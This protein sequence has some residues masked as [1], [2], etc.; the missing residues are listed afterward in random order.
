MLLFVP[1]GL[2]QFKTTVPLIVNNRAVQVEIEITL[3]SLT[4]LLR[5]AFQTIDPLT[6]LPPEGLN[7]FLPP[8]DG[9]GRGQG[10]L[11]YVV[12]PKAG[13]ATGAQIKNIALITFD[14]NEPIA[15][16]QVDP[17]DPSKGTDPD[18]ERSTPSTPACL[19][20]A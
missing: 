17:H 14:V 15:T 9:A 3:N 6:G 1:P 11:S 5:A 2:R 13:L 10:Y 12:Q 8:E 18:K 7:G 4:G 19:R 20:A 16:N